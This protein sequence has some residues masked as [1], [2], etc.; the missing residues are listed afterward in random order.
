MQ[1]LLDTANLNDALA[2][3]HRSPIDY[4]EGGLRITMEN[5]PVIG[6]RV[7]LNGVEGEVELTGVAEVNCVIRA[8]QRAVALAERAPALLIA[9]E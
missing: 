4:T 2:C 7:V 9:A 6:L 5:H 1:A 3:D 8:L